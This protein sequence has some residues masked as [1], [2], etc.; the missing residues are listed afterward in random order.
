MTRLKV[1]PHYLLPK[2]RITIWAGLVAN[3]KSIKFKNWFITRFVN[4]YGVN[5]SEALESDPTKYAC[6]NDF[7]IRHLKPDARVFANSPLVSPVDGAVSEIGRLA[8]NQLMQAKGKTYSAQDLLGGDAQLAAVFKD[9]YFA[10][11]Y[12]S[13]KDYHRVHMPLTGQLTFAK[14]IPGKLFSVQPLTTQYIP[15][16]FARNERLVTL[17]D[18]ALGQMALIF[19]GATIVGKIGTVFA[20]EMDRTQ[21][22]WTKSFDAPI[23]L[24]KGS[25]LGYFKLGS[26]VIMMLTKDADFN[27]RVGAG[28]SIKLGQD[29]IN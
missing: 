19:V 3:I 5:M 16:L 27:W 6:F 4:A 23:E 1:L 10:T 26:T 7:F 25:E 29:L 2:K 18:T 28:A 8:S 9:G 20:G 24:E 14:Y 15:H 11:L 22:I 12:L 21:G 13:P 17:F